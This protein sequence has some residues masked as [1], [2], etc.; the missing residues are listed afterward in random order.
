MLGLF[1]R[2]S[3]HE[4]KNT[5]PRGCRVGSGRV[6]YRQEQLM[7]CAWTISVQQAAVASL[8]AFKDCELQGSWDIQT[9]HPMLRIVISKIPLNHQDGWKKTVFGV[10]RCC[11]NAKKCQEF[12]LLQWWVFPSLFWWPALGNYLNDM[13]RCRTSLR[14]GIL[15]SIIPWCHD[16]KLWEPPK[17][18]TKP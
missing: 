11:K 10:W 9:L 8:V 6:A 16:W 4:L 15:A 14:V 7:L 12:S 5:A 13:K 2:H 1:S 3:C 17:N 18:T